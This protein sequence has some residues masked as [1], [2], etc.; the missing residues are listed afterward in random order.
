MPGSATLPG[1]GA[2]TAAGSEYSRG[3]MSGMVEVEAG[4]GDEHR[5]VRERSGDL[6]ERLPDVHQLQR[7][8]GSGLRIGR[9]GRGG[10]RREGGGRGEGGE[11]TREVKAS[12]GH[13]VAVS[14]GLDEAIMKDRFMESS[15]LIAA[16]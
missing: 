9:R 13:G 3:A 7:L 1:F 6:V 2:G 4:V 16:A 12:A 11:Q 10:A 15:R 14:W 8:L 5:H